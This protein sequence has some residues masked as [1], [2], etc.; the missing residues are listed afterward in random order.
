[1]TKR[2]FYLRN[3]VAAAICLAGTMMFSGCE[4]KENPIDPNAPAFI[5]FSFAGQRGTPNIDAE[6]RTVKA[7]AECGINLASLSPE[8]ILSPEGTTAKIDGETQ[9]S[10]ISA[11]NFG[12]PIIYTLTNL[13]G[14]TAEWTVT[15]THPSDCPKNSIEAAKVHYF[16]APWDNYYFCFDNYGKQ[17][18][19][20][21]TDAQTGETQIHIYDEING[22]YD[23]WDS[24]DGWLSD[25]AP[26]AVT[27]A[28][29]KSSTGIF[30]TSV[31]NYPYHYYNMIPGATKT[32]ETVAG[33]I[34]DV[35]RIPPSAVFAVW[36]DCVMLEI[37]D[38]DGEGIKAID[39]KLGCPANAF[40]RT[41]VLNWDLQ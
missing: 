34:C 29:L 5:A 4:P 22:F 36:Q 21:F 37:T 10:G 1:M 31:Y 24:Q 23:I 7:I 41:I 11:A 20:E 33:Q 16:S 25:M 14:E 38:D 40:T 35:Y 19:M 12:K 3:V 8:F 30:L 17:C 9:I 15:I 18:R 28:N 13:D 2:N 6:K 26:S 27:P 32:T 39:A